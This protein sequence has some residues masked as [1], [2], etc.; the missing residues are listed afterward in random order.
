M[1][2]TSIDHGVSSHC[3]VALV[4]FRGGHYLGGGGS[5]VKEISMKIG[6]KIGREVDNFETIGRFNY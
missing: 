6:E 3:G 1:V 2:N 5:E 4:S